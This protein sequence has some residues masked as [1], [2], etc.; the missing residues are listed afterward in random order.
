MSGLPRIEAKALTN[1][2]LLWFQ[3]VRRLQTLG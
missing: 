2:R 3:R 1:E